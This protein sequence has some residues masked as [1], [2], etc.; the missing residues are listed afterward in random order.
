MQNTSLL[1]ACVC[2]YVC[3]L[4]T[5]VWLAVVIV[6]LLCGHI[7]VG[8]ILS[9]QLQLADLSPGVLD[10]LW[11]L[12]Q[13]HTARHHCSEI[14]MKGLLDKA[15]LFSFC[16]QRKFCIIPDYT[17]QK[18]HSSSLSKHGPYI[19][20]NATGPSRVHFSFMRVEANVPSRHYSPAEMR[21]G[22]QTSG[23]LTS[24]YLHTPRFFS[25]SNL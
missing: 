10:P 6:V 5:C 14:I 16:C 24:F 21:S 12:Q 23:K 7:Q 19:T 8:L 1:I 9:H 3:V 18:T 22:L 13:K 25:F 17:I 20:H 2:S 11:H 15:N 4:P